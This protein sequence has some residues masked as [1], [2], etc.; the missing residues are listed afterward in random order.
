M[1]RKTKPLLFR[2]PTC[3]G[4]GKIPLLEMPELSHRSVEIYALVER[5]YSYRQVMEIFK[6][7]SPS[8]VHYHIKKVEK[9]LSR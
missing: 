7:S 8:V 2:C 4:K 1:L 5:G 6:I 9:F 3:H